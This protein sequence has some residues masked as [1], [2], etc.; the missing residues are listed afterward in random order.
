MVYDINTTQNK[1]Q[2]YIQLL[3]T[4]FYSKNTYLKY[5]LRVNKGSRSIPLFKSHKSIER[6]QNP[7]YKL[8]PRETHEL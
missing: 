2:G 4:A 3:S 6:N 1:G 7:G 8:K 5:P